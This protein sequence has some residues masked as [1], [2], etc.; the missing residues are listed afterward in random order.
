MPI[1]NVKVYNDGSH[2]IAIPPKLNPPP[3]R[4]G[5][6]K[7][8]LKQIPIATP[9]EENSCTQTVKN[10]K[11]IAKYAENRAESGDNVKYITVDLKEIF[12]EEYKTHSDKRKSEKRRLIIA[13]LSPYFK[14]EKETKEFVNIQLERKQRNFIVR[15]TR[16]YRKVYG[17]EFNYFCTEKYFYGYYFSYEILL[18]LLL[19]HF[20]ALR[21]NLQ[22]SF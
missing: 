7:R 10:D 9:T 17:N 14:S 20:F 11:V 19:A 4:K 22:N 12:E 2:P 5:K 1:A 6:K 15:R 18:N 21:I 3:K 16:L 8:Y 13:A